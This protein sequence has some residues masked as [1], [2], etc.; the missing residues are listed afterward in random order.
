MKVY[1][2]RSHLKIR[3]S[4]F[5]EMSD[6][7]L[8]YSPRLITFRW[9]CQFQICGVVLFS[10]CCCCFIVVLLPLLLLLMFF[11][12]EIW[13]FSFGKTLINPNDQCSHHIET[14]QLIFRA[15]Q[16]TGFYVMGKLV[17]KALIC[18][19]RYYC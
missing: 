13:Y 4:H 12:F 18:R 6:V 16:L 10:C 14:S 15:N 8:R 5:L 9:R 1:H 11:I 17:A 7:L 19:L 3:D 2:K